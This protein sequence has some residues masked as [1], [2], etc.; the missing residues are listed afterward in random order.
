MP[1]V[2]VFFDF[3]GTLCHSRA[4][5]LPLFRSAAKRAG[6]ELPW[7]QYVRA[8]EACWDELWPEAPG[9]VGKRPAFADLVHERALRVVGF[10]G[11]VE[12]LVEAI[13]DEAV[14]ARWNTPYPETEST[15]SEL[16]KQGVRLHVV[17]GHVDYLPII[18]ANLGWARF[19]RTV[20]FT[21]EVGVQKPDPRVFHFAM[22]RAGV[23]PSK[24]V[25][26]GDSWHADYLGARAVEMISVW[27]NRNRSAAP[28]P[29]REISSLLDLQPILSSLDRHG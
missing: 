29:C 19:F 11:P 13:R 15:L 16:T 6:V 24:A 27:L 8:N 26:V 20:T 12:P 5:I 2:E 17:S 14:S 9:M 18:I 1:D 25:F 22:K 3:G 7:E 10:R 28:E 4:D 21:Q 23:S